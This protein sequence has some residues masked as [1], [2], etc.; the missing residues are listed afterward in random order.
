MT[1]DGL[2]IVRTDVEVDA[3]DFAVALQLQQRG[4]VDD[5]TTM[6]DTTLDDQIRLD[7]PNDLLH[8]HHVLR[9]L[10]DRAAH[11]REVVAVLVTSRFVE[12]ITGQ[13]SEFLVVTLLGDLLTAFGFEG[14]V[15]AV[16]GH[17]QSLNG[18]WNEA[19]STA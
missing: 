13:A 11:P 16:V 17:V 2:A 10:D 18:H 6:G 12:E 14:L 8:C 19:L 1:F 9:Q 4:V 7:L 5:R 15:D 3:Q